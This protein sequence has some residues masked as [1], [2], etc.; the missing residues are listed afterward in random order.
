MTGQRRTKRVPATMWDDAFTVELD[1]AV[2]GPECQDF[3]VYRDGVLI[4]YVTSYQTRSERK[5]SG[6][7][8]VTRGAYFR[9]WAQ[10]SVGDAT[11]PTYEQPRF[12]YYMQHRSMSAAIRRLVDNTKEIAS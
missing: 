2:D 5:I 9:A 10:R 6:S 12:D 4:G 3:A 8:L 1:P 11:K 7:R